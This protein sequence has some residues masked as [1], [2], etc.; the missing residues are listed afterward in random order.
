MDGALVGRDDD[1]R[2]LLGWWA[3]ARA[4]A[5]RVV[6]LGGEPGIGKTRIAH[7]LTEQVAAAGAATAWGR[8]T[9]QEGAPPFWP[10][11][12]VLARLDRD[13]ALAGAAGVDPE[14]ER[15]ARFEAVASALDGAAD[16]NGLLI[17]STTCTRST[18]ATSASS[19]TSPMP[20]TAR[21]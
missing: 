16:G 21:C 11:R 7:E 3:E 2:T 14:V 9:E 4:G 15:F 5:P 17:V 6:L 18:P 10:W 20:S 19:S 1:V 8:G 13:D 12:Q